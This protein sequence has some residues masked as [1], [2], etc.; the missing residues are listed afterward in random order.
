M[1]TPRQQI[2]VAYDYSQSAATALTRGID[3]AC[4]SPQY[5]LHFVVVIDPRAGI[6]ALPPGGA[7]D[8]VYA[9]KVQADLSEQ[10]RKLFEARAT[11]GEVH[12]FVHA[13]L[14]KPAE[15]LLHVASELGAD[16]IILG[17]RGHTGLRRMV[18]GS[19]AEHVVR[20]A[21][22]PVVVERPK[23]YANVDLLAVVEVEA[24]AK[25]WIPPLR[26]SYRDTVLTRPS[27]WPL[28]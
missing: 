2:V 26:F 18:L 11:T 24:S 27:D 14:G 20:E 25:R 8:Y 28:N 4:A 16:L 9:A 12:Y 7:I 17:S 10:L 21:G 6:G 15:E 1:S 13:R 3:L 22:C 23:T 5:V 19:V